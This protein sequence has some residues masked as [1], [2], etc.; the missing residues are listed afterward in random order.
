VSDLPPPPPPPSSGQP[1]YPAGPPFAPPGG[2]A[3]P[4]GT[5]GE[6]HPPEEPSGR[7]GRRVSIALAVAAV[8]AL[9][10]ATVV[11]IARDDGPDT[12]AAPGTMAPEDTTGGEPPSSAPTTEP[13]GPPLSQDELVALVEELQEFVA[14]ER[15]LEFL[16]PVDVE[17]ADGADFEARLLED[18]EEDADDIAD[19]E[20]FYKA[21]G[22]L[23]PDADLLEELRAI[24][25]AGVLGFYDPETDE[26]V[27]RGT[28]LSPYVRQT[29]VHELV[30]ALDDQH[31]ELGRDDEYD[32]R[33]DE[34]A[35]GFSAVV[36]GNARRIEQAWLTEQP[37]DV[38]EQASAEEEAFG[39]TI[40]VDA[41]PPMLLFEISAPYGFGEVLV[42]AVEA[43][44]GERAIDAALDDP[45]TTSEQVIFPRLYLDREPRIEVPPPPADGEVV[46]DGVVGALFWF[47]LLTDGGTAPDTAAITAIQGWGG[48]WAVTWRD[49]EANCVRIDV[50]GDTQD[51][52]D[53]L[54]TAL[55]EWAEDS[56]AGEISIVDERVRVDS[57]VTGA[58]ATPPQV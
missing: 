29:I 30:H 48:D 50:V 58:G 18:F 20:V 45:P 17:L 34:I 6:H 23:E 46:D 7:R 44:G 37:E 13:A 9:L 8:L 38:Q 41:F 40:D 53:E 36:E 42:D 31:F 27:V 39:A 3:A 14:Q 25:S 24:Y 33:K 26:L 32:E 21:L 12:Q 1:G 57:C 22:L 16:R 54:E 28:S 4:S 19:V 55:R 15:G 35:A 43:E 2:G 52:T 11:V 47:G 56:V 51:D 10:A 49:G 5:A